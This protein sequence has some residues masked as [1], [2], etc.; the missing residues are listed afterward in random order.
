MELIVELDGI[1]ERIKAVNPQLRDL[2]E[3]TG[4]TLLEL[5]VI[6]PARFASGRHRTD[7]LV[8]RRAGPAPALL[9]GTPAGICLAR[10]ASAG[11]RM[12]RRDVPA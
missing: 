7:R 4:S 2:D 10:R 8:V 9:G 11:V 12:L 1:D 3:A 5:H 6:G